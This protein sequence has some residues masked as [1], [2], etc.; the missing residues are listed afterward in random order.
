MDCLSLLSLQAVD[1]WEE[2]FQDDRKVD[3]KDW[4][5]KHEVQIPTCPGVMTWLERTVSDRFPRAVPGTSRWY[6]L[7]YHESKQNI[8]HQQTG[9]SRLVL[10]KEITFS[11]DFVGVNWNMEA[12]LC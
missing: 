8:K 12:K 7:Q 6:H 9:S 1:T 5:K 4:K 10:H 11:L 3:D 2:P